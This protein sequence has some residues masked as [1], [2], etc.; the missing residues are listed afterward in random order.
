[1]QASKRSKPEPAPLAPI[2]V[3]GVVPLVEIAPIHLASEQIYKG[4][5]PVFL[6]GIPSLFTANANGLADVSGNAENVALRA[7]VDHPDLRIILTV[8]EGLYRIVARRSAGIT[9][10]ADLEGKR[11]AVMPDGS[12]DFFLHKMLKTANLTAADVVIVPIAY[13]TPVTPMVAAREVDA[14]ATWEPE[15]ERAAEAFGADT[16]EFDGKGIY[17]EVYNLNTTT[18]VLADP[19]KRASIVAYVR[20]I[21]EASRRITAD[22]KIGYSIVAAKSGLG[23][24]FV[25]N[26]WHHHTF[27]AVIVPDLLDVMVEEEAW[28]AAKSE[29][30][31]RTREQLATLI[32]DS[33]V[34][35][36]LKED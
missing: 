30:P 27:P 16:I 19:A 18:G 23:P 36:A 28:L 13:N 5:A 14:V 21:I 10:I 9:K 24:E 15:S 2:K 4:E 32:D 34:R 3:F 20:A 26:I 31:A 1:M 33:I 11:I 17:R 7:S 29:R 8:T 12:S 6:G 25:A 35:E 22:P